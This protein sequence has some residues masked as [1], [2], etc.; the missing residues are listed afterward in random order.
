V[1]ADGAVLADVVADG[2]EGS[3]EEEL[4]V[5]EQPAMHSRATAVRATAI[6]VLGTGPRYRSLPR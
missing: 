1:L 2:A 5:A 6:L 4:P 3:G